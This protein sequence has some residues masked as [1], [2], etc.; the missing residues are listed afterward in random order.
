[1]PDRIATVTFTPTT[2]QLDYE[3]R[4]DDFNEWLL[5]A[6]PAELLEGGYLIARALNRGEL[7][8]LRDYI[9]ERTDTLDTPEPKE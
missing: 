1:M 8:R 7:A 9:N 3:H 5:R 4:P 2:R 6:S